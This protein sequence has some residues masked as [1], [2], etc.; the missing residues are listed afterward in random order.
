MLFQYFEND[1]KKY[2]L[3]SKGSCLSLKK[4]RNPLDY[5]SS[6]Y[7]FLHTLKGKEQQEFWIDD[8]NCTYGACM[9]SLRKNWRG[10]KIA[11]SQGDVES[12]IDYATRI[13][14]TQR[15][16][17]FKVAVFTDLPVEGVQKYDDI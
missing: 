7:P 3:S 8:A 6:R 9:S 11:K 14:D 12:M 13:Q 16:I 17:G 4:E 2:M 15:A 10:Y 1:Y 5:V